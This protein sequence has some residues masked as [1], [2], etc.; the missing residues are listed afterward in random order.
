MVEGEEEVVLQ[1]KFERKMLRV[2]EA[3]SSC[4]ANDAVFVLLT[5]LRRVLTNSSIRRDYLL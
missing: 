1:D 2:N 5:T 3:L 4:E